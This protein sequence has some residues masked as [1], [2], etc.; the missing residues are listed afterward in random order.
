MYYMLVMQVLQGLQTFIDDV[1]ND[2]LCKGLVVAGLQDVSQASSV[3][4]LDEDPESIFKVVPI[5]IFNNVFMFADGHQCYF[6][7]N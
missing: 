4:V 7:S 5:V 6:I 2:I 3:H 1:L